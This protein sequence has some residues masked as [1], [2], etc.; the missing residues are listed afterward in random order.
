MTLHRT[1]A[2]D[3]HPM[4][5]VANTDLEALFFATDEV[6]RRPVRIRSRQRIPVVAVG[7]VLLA[8][9]VGLATLGSV[10]FGDQ[11][12]DEVQSMTLQAP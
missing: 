2:E 3:L 1:R 8:S 11:I 4:D 6:P 5:E 12:V 9:I 10:A 7:A